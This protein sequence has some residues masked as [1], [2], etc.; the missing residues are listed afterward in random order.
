[1]STSSVDFEKAR[2]MDEKVLFDSHVVTAV[3][4]DT[5][6]A[7]HQ[8]TIGFSPPLLPLKQSLTFLS[9]LTDTDAEFRKI[10]IKTDLYL[11]PLLW[12]LGGLRRFPTFNV[13]MKV[14]LTNTA[15]NI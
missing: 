15:S 8:C 11:M 3:P 13:L 7:A 1:M 12:V 6:E 4:E 14:N 10:R 2:D 9:F 5:V